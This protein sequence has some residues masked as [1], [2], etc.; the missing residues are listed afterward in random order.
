VSVH[1]GLCLSEHKVYRLGDIVKSQATQIFELLEVAGK[2]IGAISPFNAT[3]K[4]KN[5]RYFI[6]DPWT[7]TE[8]DKSILSKRISEAIKQAVNDNANS[9]ITAE[10]YFWLVIGF[11]LSAR[12]K[13]FQII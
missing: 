5:P 10:S 4:L 2:K 1:T 6:P 13:N 11:V 12:V 3:N 8:S 7:N 9:K